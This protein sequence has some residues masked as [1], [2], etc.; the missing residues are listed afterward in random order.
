MNNL[1]IYSTVGN[2]FGL[3]LCLGYG[4]YCFVNRGFHAKGKGWKTK[5]EAPKSY[6]FI[7][8]MIIFF[9]VIQI[10]SI[11]YRLYTYYSI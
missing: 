2:L 11:V 10:G 3:V 6:Y 7:L 4:L 9:C 1:L 5:E 8:G